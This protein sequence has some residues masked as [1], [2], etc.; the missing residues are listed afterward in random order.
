MTDDLQCFKDRFEVSDRAL[1]QGSY[2]A[3]YLAEEVG[4]STQI[5]CKIVDIDAAANKLADNSTYD[6][7]GEDWSRRARSVARAKQ[8]VMREVRILSKLSHVS[9]E[10]SKPLHNSH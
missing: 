3:V 7:L 2:G 10:M 8:V 1:G 4:T 9:I 5:A 6:P